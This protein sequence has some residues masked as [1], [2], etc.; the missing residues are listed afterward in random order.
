MVTEYYFSVFP[1][2][3]AQENTV[4]AIT[5]GETTPIKGSGK[6]KGK[7]MEK[8]KEMTD[9]KLHLRLLVEKVAS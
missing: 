2:P 1:T 6:S 7:A 4:K 8:E 3:D 5:T 9:P